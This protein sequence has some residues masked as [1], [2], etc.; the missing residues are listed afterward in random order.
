[1]RVKRSVYILAIDD[2]LQK[3]GW[4]PLG[5][6][7]AVLIQIQCAASMKRGI[8]PCYHLFFYIDN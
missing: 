3:T 4:K 6:M 1:M 5:Y 7:V 8:Q 2:Q